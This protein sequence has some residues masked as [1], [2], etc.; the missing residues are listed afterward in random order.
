MWPGEAGKRKAVLGCETGVPS[1]SSQFTTHY[2]RLGWK[3]FSSGKYL[4]QII[5]IVKIIIIINGDPLPPKSPIWKQSWGVSSTGLR[6]KLSEQNPLIPVA[7]GLW[8]EIPL[9]G[10]QVRKSQSGKK[11]T[12]Y[13]MHTWTSPSG[14]NSHPSEFSIDL[15]TTTLLLKCKGRNPLWGTRSHQN[16]NVVCG[17]ISGRNTPN[18]RT[19]ERAK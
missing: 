4:L 9:G 14:I 5:V 8:P 18:W 13:Q 12:L 15:G 6:G 10:N 16:L 2:Q 17:W 7:Q 1:I 19:E 11:P 3:G